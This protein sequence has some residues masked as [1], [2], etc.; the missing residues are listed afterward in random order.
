MALST[1]LLAILWIVATFVLYFI[2]RLLPLAVVI[3]DALITVFL[4]IS[5]MGT[6]SS[7]Y[8]ASSC[9]LVFLDPFFTYTSTLWTPCLVVKASFAMELLS[10]Y[11]APLPPSPPPSL[12]RAARQTT[13]R[14]K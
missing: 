2:G 13:G 7:G 3:I 14:G 12:S 11:P 10:M 1:S 4:F 6:D 5:M 8:V 9:Q